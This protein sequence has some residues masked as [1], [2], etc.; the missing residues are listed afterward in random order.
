MVMATHGT[1]RATEIPSPSLKEI[2][3][4]ASFSVLLAVFLL[5]AHFLFVFVVDVPLFCGYCSFNFFWLFHLLTSFPFGTCQ[6]LLYLPPPSL[7][8]FST[9]LILWAIIFAYFSPL[10]PLCFSPPITP[11][12]P[13]MSIPLNNFPIYSWCTNAVIPEGRHQTTLA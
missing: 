11:F 9:S 7:P 6:P 5:S 10:Q 12:S 1:R 8:F 3:Q 4:S 2:S 13:W